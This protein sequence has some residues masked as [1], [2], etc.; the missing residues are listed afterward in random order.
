[1]LTRIHQNDMNEYHEKEPTFPNIEFGD[2][3]QRAFNTGVPLVH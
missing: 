1:M 2:V 3:V